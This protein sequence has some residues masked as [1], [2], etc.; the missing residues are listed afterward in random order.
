MPRPFLMLLFTEVRGIGILG[1]S[2]AGSWIKPR[3]TPEIAL[4]HT[5][6]S[7]S[8]PELVT[9]MDRYAR[10]WML[11]VQTRHA[12]KALTTKPHSPPKRAAAQ[13]R[14]RSRSLALRPWSWPGRLCSPSTFIMPERVTIREIPRANSESYT[15]VPYRSEP[16]MASMT[17]A[18]ATSS[19]PICLKKSKYLSSSASERALSFLSFI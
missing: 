9:R 17:M 4:S 3:N 14:A 6:H 7:P 10:L 1:S 16:L 8:P 11:S 2:L 19:V 5:P 18:T 12:R 13:S 15:A